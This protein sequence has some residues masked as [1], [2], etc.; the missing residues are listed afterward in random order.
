MSEAIYNAE[1][2]AAMRLDVHGTIL[3][4]ISGGSDSDIVMDIVERF[5]GD[6]DVKYVFFDTGLEYDATKR[7]L[8]Y[9]EER[10]RITIERMNAVVPIP[11]SCKTRGVPFLSKEVSQR[12]HHLQI[13]G[14]KW[15]D[16]PFDELL[17]EYPRCNWGVRWWCSKNKAKKGNISNHAYLKEYM[18]ENPP[19]MPISDY[20]CKGAKK[21]VAKLAVKKYRAVLQIM[22]LR[23]DEGGVRARAIKSCFS[24]ETAKETAK[25]FPVFFFT[26]EDKKTYELDHTITHSDCYRV[27]GMRRTGCAACPFGSDFEDTLETIEQ[28]EPKLFRAA[29][30]IFGKAYEYTRKYREFKERKKVEARE[31]REREKKAPIAGQTE[32]EEFHVKA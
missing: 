18:I 23:R 27:Y 6:A 9:L 31:A 10:Y 25:Y 24:P 16:K 11:I 21:R 1:L 4:S 15:E 19:N 32:M 14:F 28:Y 12:I 2:R 13:N 5:K 8:T 3:V 17:V 26:E 29:N 30:A 7:H 22:G 20:C